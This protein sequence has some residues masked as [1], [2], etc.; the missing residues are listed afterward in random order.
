[1]ATMKRGLAPAHPGEVLRDIWGDVGMTQ[2]EFATFIGVS[3]QTVAEL[4]NGRRN[5]SA[6]MAHRL[7]LSVGGSPKLWMNL[8]ATFDLWNTEK[9]NRRKYAKIGRVRE[10]DLTPAS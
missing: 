8:Q 5:M 2:A 7:A 1:M 6:D 3:R 4:L 10:Q 9:A